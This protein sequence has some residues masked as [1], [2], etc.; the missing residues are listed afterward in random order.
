MQ[1]ARSSNVTLKLHIPGCFE[2]WLIVDAGHQPYSKKL[3]LDHCSPV[4]TTMAD[5]SKLLCHLDE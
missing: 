1:L 5:D 4:A 2:Q 3:W